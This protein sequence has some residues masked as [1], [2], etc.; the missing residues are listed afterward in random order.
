MDA[1]KMPFFLAMVVATAA[2]SVGASAGD[3]SLSWELPAGGAEIAGAKVYYG[4]V[5]SNYTE[6]VDVGYTNRCTIT[7]LLTGVTYYFSGTSYDA[8]GQESVFCS[9]VA[10]TLT[11]NQPPQVDAGPDGEG[12]LAHAIPLYGS[13]TD[14]G[15]PVGSSVTVSWS[16]LSGPGT[17]VFE[18]ALAAVTQATFSEPGS[19]R[20]QLAASDGAASAGDDVVITVRAATV[21]KPPTNLRVLP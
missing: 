17:V 20:L 19:Y 6:V 10:K 16:S 21:P 11:A 8:A 3:V 4:V 14:D 18:N 5:S 9:E 13:V 2:M 12:V 1:D 15:L 7:G